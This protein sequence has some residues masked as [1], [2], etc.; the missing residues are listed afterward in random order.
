MAFIDELREDGFSCFT[1]KV[2]PYYA[3]QEIYD[4][5]R[6]KKAITEAGTGN[7]YS[8]LHITVEW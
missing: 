6:F 5:G 3:T 8:Y 7:V 2:M 1:F 4:I